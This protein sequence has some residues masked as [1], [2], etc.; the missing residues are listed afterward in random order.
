MSSKSAPLPEAQHLH[1]ITFDNVVTWSIFA[2]VLLI[3]IACTLVISSRLSARGFIPMLV[4]LL[5][6]AVPFALTFLTY[7]VYR[8]YYINE[9]AGSKQYLNLITKRRTRSTESIRQ[10]RERHVDIGNYVLEMSL[11][12][13]IMSLISSVLIYY[14]ILATMRLSRTPAL[15]WGAGVI[16]TY[17]YTGTNTPPHPIFFPT[18]MLWMTY[19]GA[20][21]ST[22]L[23]IFQRFTVQHLVPRTYFNAALK[24]LFG[25]FASAL[26]YLLFKAT[27]E[28]F[29]LNTAEVTPQTASMLLLLGFFAGML[30]MNTIQI[31]VR[32]I[33]AWIGA[34]Q[35]YELPVT[36]IQGINAQMAMF[37]NEEG[38]WSLVDLA[39]RD[40]EKLSARVHVDSEVIVHWKEQAL[41]LL[42]LGTQENIEHFRK[43]G[44]TSLAH[45]KALRDVDLSDLKA[46]D[47]C[48]PPTEGQPSLALLAVL[49]TAAQNL[50]AMQNA[51]P[52]EDA[53][54]LPE[55]NS[56]TPQ[57]E[58]V[59]EVITSAG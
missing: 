48:T 39:Q 10:E 31:V 58:V 2:I 11:L 28:F 22:L 5:V 54:P 24:Y 44:I 42:M 59:G 25:M 46:Q 20:M 51:A 47:F 33:G 29:G 13:V 40:P 7:F 26:L 34:G 14:D 15:Y 18:M 19:L 37:L 50:E 3:S 17:F 41:L 43:L 4:S 55:Q 1:R 38:I 23:M 35:D 52:V 12:I 57:T 8:R 45:L 6:S 16:P 27:P 49:K 36:L 9:V 30:P 53:A 21:A 56:V 32:R